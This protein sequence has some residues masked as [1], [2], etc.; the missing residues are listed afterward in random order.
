MVERIGFSCTLLMQMSS[1]SLQTPHQA[2]SSTIL[3]RLSATHR[4]SATPE[5]TVVKPEESVALVKYQTV[6][7][8][9]RS[10]TISKSLVWQMGAMWAGVI[11]I[12]FLMYQ[13]TIQDLSKTQERVLSS[14]AA[15]M[16][17]DSAD[18]T[19]LNGKLESLSGH[20][21]RRLALF[22]EKIKSEDLSI[23][24]LMDKMKQ[25]EILR[26]SL[27]AER[28]L[29]KRDSPAIF[30]PASPTIHTTSKKMVELSPALAQVNEHAHK[31][32]NLIIPV[33]GATAHIDAL[34]ITDY[35]LIER[36]DRSHARTINHVVPFDTFGHLV[37]VHCMEDGVDYL[38]TPEGDWLSISA[39]KRPRG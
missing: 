15:A 8:L 38:L 26:T 7:D 11:L 33:R 19:S 30:V 12:L 36:E 13:R 4:L 21:S 2:P 22:D 14:V 39:E 9:M 34:G 1:P 28:T 5:D 18:F 31:I 17:K 32:D 35:W 3:D 6:E 25:E 23:K 29:Q 27:S 37:K 24:R 10:R 16:T 20:T